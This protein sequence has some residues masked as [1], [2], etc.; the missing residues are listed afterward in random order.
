MSTTVYVISPLIPQILDKIA[1][2]N[3][4]REKNFLFH[5]NYGIIDKNKHY[6]L[7]YIHSVIASFLTIT[8]MSAIDTIIFAIV[9]HA[10]GMF[11]LLG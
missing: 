11:E 6:T 3:E 8:N 7:I 9:Q 2:L 4:S 1:P 10:C 5:V